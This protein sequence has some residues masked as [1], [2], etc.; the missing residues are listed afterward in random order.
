MQK[1]NWQITL[2]LLLIVSYTQAQNLSLTGRVTDKATGQ[3]ILGANIY[4]NNSTYGTVT[5]QNG[6]F[7]IRN[8]KQGNY[9]LI[10]SCV[11]YHRVKQSIDLLPGMKALNFLLETSDLDL[12]EVVVTGTGTAHHLKSAPVQTELIKGK[13]IEELAPADFTDLMLQVSPSFDFSPGTMGNFMQLNG[14]GNDYI[15]IL[16]DGK[17]LYGDVGGQ[18]DLNR[19]NPTDIDRIEIVKGASSALYGSE[20]IA[21][22]INII[23]KKSKQQVYVQNSSQLSKYGQWQQHNSLDLN[24]GRFSS[25]TSLDHKETDGWQLSHYELD[26]ND[27]LVETDANTQNKTSDYTINQEFTFAPTDKL[28]LYIAGTGY[29]KDYI[30]PLTVSDYGYY[31]KDFTYAGGMSYLLGGNNRLQLDWNSDRNRYYYKYTA[32]YNGNMKGDK[33]LQTQQQRADLNIKAI[34]N[35]SDKNTLSVGSEY[36]NEKLESEGRLTGEEADAYTLAVYAQEELKLQDKLSV[37]TG[38]RY[39]YHKEFRNTLTPKI[40]TLYRAGDFNLRGTYAHGFKA[41]TMKELY[42]HYEKGSTLYLG[43]TELNPQTSD[44]YAASVGY[45]VSGISFS[46]TAYQNNVQDLIDYETIDTSDEDAANGITN[47]RK[48]YNISKASTRGVDFLFETG[49]GAGFNLGGAYSYVDARNKT[50][51]V[52]LENVARHYGSIHLSYDCSRK[53]Y[54]LN[55]NLN[56][57]FQDEKFYDDGNAKAY[58]LWRLTTVHRFFSRRVFNFNLTAGIDNLFDYVDD[59]PYGSHYGTI[60]PGRTVFCGLK[61]EFKN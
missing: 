59:S 11:G 19:I 4:F 22:V 7:K 28:Q 26:K 41:P 35:L 49:L 8:V 58:S 47:T 24:F 23:T 38:L 15:L 34:F 56:G 51:D 54:K 40:S 18:T 60:N 5:D 39:V 33:V 45:I 14:L 27:N 36:V 32:D 46:A 16:V 13:L 12:G 55:I 30:K 48:H 31:F 37:V 20:A 1:I 2:L 17:R 52:R 9:E 25:T 42:Y 6:N 3:A 10:I 43:N 29:K 61:V 44:Y 21:G 57:R 50:E 53:N